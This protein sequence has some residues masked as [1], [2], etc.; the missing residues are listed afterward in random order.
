[1]KLQRLKFER[2]F[3]KVYIEKLIK[4]LNNN[5]IMQEEYNN[6]QKERDI[7]QPWNIVQPWI[8]VKIQSS[9]S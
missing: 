5:I 9:E 3:L 1:M 4:M 2:L 7:V 6:P 8:A